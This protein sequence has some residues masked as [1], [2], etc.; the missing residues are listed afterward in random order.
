MTGWKDQNTEVI[1]E[2]GSIITVTDDMDLIAVGDTVYGIRFTES[3]YGSIN[4]DQRIDNIVG[5]EVGETVPL[6]I[7]PERGYKVKK[8]S[9]VVSNGVF[10]F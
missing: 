6:Y 9:Y 8:V 3:Q 1:Y 7:E 10:L 2:P 5:A 4:T